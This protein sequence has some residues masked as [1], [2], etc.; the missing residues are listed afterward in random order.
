MNFKRYIAYIGIAASGILAG[1]SDEM[2]VFISDAEME[3]V[4]VEGESVT[5]SASTA[6]PSLVT[7]TRAFSDEADLA[8]LHL[9]LVEFVDNGNPLTNTFSRIYEAQDEWVD[10]GKGVVNYDVTLRATASPRILHLVALPKGET[11]TAD[12][13]VE[14]TVIPGLKT[15]D[16]VEA[17]WRRLSFP[18]GYCSPSGDGA[19]T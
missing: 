6:I 10:T 8:N 5:V 17:Y 14:A 16:G 3:G 11:L 15:S 1:C 18:D 9:Y 13:G 12:Y 7:A 4:R 19:W 2:P